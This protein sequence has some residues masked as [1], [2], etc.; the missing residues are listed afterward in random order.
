MLGAAEGGVNVKSEQQQ[1]RRVGW[2][3][4]ANPN[5][6]VAHRAGLPHPALRGHAVTGRHAG[7]VID[8]SCR[9]VPVPVGVRVAHPNLREVHSIPAAL[10]AMPPSFPHH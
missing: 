9:S 7:G 5:V 1:Q 3:E 2:G 4:L 8:R 10:D 6:T